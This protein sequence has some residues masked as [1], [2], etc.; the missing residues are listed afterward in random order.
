ML[1]SEDT[2]DSKGLLTCDLCHIKFNPEKVSWDSGHNGP[3]YYAIISAVDDTD[4]CPKCYYYLPRQSKCRDCGVV[5]PSR[6]LLFMHLR[7]VNHF[8]N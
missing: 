6:N 2:C 3:H 4:I 7:L 5:F 8:S 1:S